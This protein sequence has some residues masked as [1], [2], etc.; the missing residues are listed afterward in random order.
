MKGIVPINRAAEPVSFMSGEPGS[1][2]NIFTAADDKK[3]LKGEE[4]ASLFSTS[5]DESSNGGVS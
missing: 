2:Q 3:N 5:H 4:A 1:K